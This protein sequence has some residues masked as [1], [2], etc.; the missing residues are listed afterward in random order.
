MAGAKSQRRDAG[1]GPPLRICFTA[2]R[3]NM[4]CGGQ[5][6]Y[7]WYLARELARLGHRID[8][9]VGPPYPDP[10]PFARSLTAVPNERFWG[11]WFL[12]ERQRFIPQPRPLRI[13]E[14]LNFFE[15]AASY[16]GF[17]PEPLA[18]SLRAFREV[19]ARL[20]SGAEYDI[21]HD[22]QCLGY[23][24]L[25][26][27]KLGIPVVTTVHHPLTVDRRASF[28][29]DETLEEAIG[30]MRF[31]PVAMQGFVARRL[32]GV[33]TSSTASA[34]V[35]HRDFRVPIERLRMLANGV[36][37]EQFRPASDAKRSTNEIVCVGRASDPNKGVENLIAAFA[38]LP[39]HLRLTL[40]DDDHP[41]SPARALARRLGCAGR[42]Q[43]T[44]RIDNAELVRRYQCASLVVVPS[45][46]EGF[47]LPAVEAM[48]CG[49]P[50]VACA[51][52]ALPEVIRATG[53]GVLVQQDS[54]AAL[55]VAIADLMARPEIRSMLGKRGC[56]RVGEI[57]AWPRVARATAAAYAEVIER[58]RAGRGRPARM[59]TSD[60]PGSRR[61]TASNPSSAHCATESGSRPSDRDQPG[62]PHASEIP[63]TT[64]SSSDAQACSRISSIS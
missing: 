14:P 43:I 23:G 1:C 47:G 18:F 55:A 21:V 37:T 53:G 4:H 38:R 45:R 40:V 54:P 6:I 32:D 34:D 2:Y 26:I 57:Y 39:E 27:R 3:G 7:L 5:G 42:L 10:M 62:T 28:E 29:R 31:Y 11:K 56:L 15:L 50:V 52:G 13:F 58:F 20:R 25:G 48:A 51:S 61:A 16:F 49:T 46:Y 30:T 59:T 44:G 9:L 8:V 19:A 63:S 60:H 22:V 64:S 12:G 24:M 36:D 33:F 41:D 35:I 17:L